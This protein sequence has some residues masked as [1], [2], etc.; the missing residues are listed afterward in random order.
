MVKAIFLTK[1]LEDEA[2]PAESALVTE[3]GNAT[4]VIARNKY[5]ETLVLISTL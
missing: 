3:D 2:P 1:H 5:S 4:H